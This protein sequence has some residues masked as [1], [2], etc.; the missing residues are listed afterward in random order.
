LA[1]TTDVPLKERP[2]QIWLY[3]LDKNNGS[4]LDHRRIRLSWGRQ[5]SQEG[6]TLDITLDDLQEIIQQG[7]NETVEFK[8]QATGKDSSGDEFV[9][10]VVA[11]ANGQGGIILVGIDDNRNVAG[12][13]DAS[14][15]K[16][17]I[18]NLVRQRCDPVPQ[19]SIDTRKV[20]EKAIILVNILS[21]KDRPYFV[22]GKGPYYKNPIERLFAS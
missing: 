10:T 13:K 21:G 8:L 17:T 7:E 11:K 19:Y 9:E 18:E 15:T 12:L 1:E 6:V 22:H 4:I 2:S 3:L 14:N 16:K 20:D 5:P